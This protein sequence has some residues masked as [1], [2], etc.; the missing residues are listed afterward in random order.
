MTRGHV[1]GTQSQCTLEEEF[2]AYLPIA[3]Q[4]G[5]RGLAAGVTIQEVLHD[6]IAEA[7]LGVDHIEWNP[8]LPSHAARNTHRRW[9]AAAV[10]GL[11]A[12]FGP[13]AQHHADHFV[14]V[15]LQQRGGYRAVDAAAH[16]D[17]YLP[18]AVSKLRAFSTSWGRAARKASTSS[19]VVWTPSVTRNEPSAHSGVRPRANSTSL[20]SGSPVLHA[21]PEEQ[22]KPASSSSMSKAFPS[23][24]LNTKLAWLASRC[25]G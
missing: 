7:F 12:G 1:I 8:H 15:L 22:A 6:D 16:G 2:P 3:G 11:A 13:E 23:T 19:S 20:G 9:C 10:A 21:E 5:I 14:T 25:S 18:H 4:A 17:H 24:P